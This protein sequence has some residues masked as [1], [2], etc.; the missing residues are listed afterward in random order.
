MRCPE[1]V[2]KM[3]ER[4]ATLDR[5]KVCDRRQVRDLLNAVCGQQG[6]TRLT[7]SHNVRVIAEYA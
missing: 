4:N 7:A 3:K 6:K 5:R 1:A 2:K